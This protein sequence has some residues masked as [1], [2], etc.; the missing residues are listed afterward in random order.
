MA[1]SVASSSKPV[2]P[3]TLRTALM[4]MPPEAQRT[5]LDLFRRAAEA[6]FGEGASSAPRF[7]DEEILDLRVAR[8]GIRPL[9]EKGKGRSL[10]RWILDLPGLVRCPSALGALDDACDRAL[11]ATR[12]MQQKS[13]FDEALLTAVVQTAA[14]DRADAVDRLRPVEKALGERTAELTESRA[15]VARLQERLDAF[16]HASAPVAG[17]M[18]ELRRARAVLLGQ[19]HHSNRFNL[20]VVVFAVVMAILA[21]AATTLAVREGRFKFSL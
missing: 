10:F 17:E 3:E 15:E 20:C 16:A 18:A 8:E 21:S 7:S 19:V 14:L 5:A 12:V 6:R 11:K 4:G 9:A 13:L 1:A 2:L